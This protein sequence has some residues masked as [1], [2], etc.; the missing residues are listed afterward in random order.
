MFNVVIFLSAGL[1][2]VAEKIRSFSPMVALPQRYMWNHIKFH[3]NCGH[4]P[5]P[6]SLMVRHL[7]PRSSNDC[8]VARSLPSPLPLPSCII[9]IITRKRKLGNQRTNKIIHI[10]LSVWLRQQTDEQTC[11]TELLCNGSFSAD[12][13]IH[14]WLPQTCKKFPATL[15]ATPVQ[16]LWLPRLDVFPELNPE[17]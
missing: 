7:P 10:V 6:K 15:A 13:R 11:E 14:E 17:A 5:A 8:N 1:L 9:L 4:V 16:L 2:R 12:A 3:S